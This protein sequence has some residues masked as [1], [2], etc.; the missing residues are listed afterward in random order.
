[1]AEAVA[2]SLVGKVVDSLFTKVKK[3]IGYMW[4]SKDN[5]EKL[6]S[7]VEKL[8]IMK[9]RV[10]D[11]IK[12]ALDDGDGLL[13]GVEKWVNEALAHISTT[14]EFL[15]EE[16]DA[17]KTCF[18]LRMCVNLKTL[19]HYGKEATNKVLSLEQHQKD[20]AAY[21]GDVSIPTPS[22]GILELLPRE[23]T[24]DLDTHKVVLEK[25]VE[26][27]EDESTQITGIWGMGGVGKTT[28][29]T[30]VAARV[31]HLFA[32]VIF[33]TVSRPVDVEKIKKDVEIAAKRITK[34]EKVLIILDDMWTELKL[35]D[36]G[37]PCGDGYPSC[38]ILLTSR[39]KSVC[40]AMNARTPIYVQS[41]PM[42]EAWVLFKRVVGERVETD[43][44]LK[45]VARKV[46]DGC[47]GLPLI[48]QVVG[49]ALKDKDDF[50]EWEKALDIIAKDETSDTG[51]ALR[52]EFARLKLSY[53]YLESEQVKS[54][55]ILCSMFP[56]DFQIPLERL[57]YYGVGL[58]V[59]KNLESL[60]VARNKVQGAVKIL[61]SSCL[62]LDGSNESFTKMHDVVREVALLI[63]SKD[64]NNVLVEAGKYLTKWEP[65][66]GSLESYTG[67]S[68]MNNRICKL[69]AGYELNIPL[70]RIFLIQENYRLSK[71]SDEFTQAMKEVEVIDFEYNNIG[72]LPKSLNQLTRLCMLNLGG[73]RSLRNVSIL[74]ELKQLEILI[75]S[76]TGITEIPQEIGKL[77]K[78]RLFH[79]ARCRG[80]SHIAPG[81]LSNLR[82]LE[83]LS[84]GYYPVE[85]G[86]YNSLV[87]IGELSKLTFLELSVQHIC[88][89][90]KG[91]YLK[92]LER[93]SIQI[94]PSEVD[95]CYD[96]S[97]CNR[98][99]ILS[100]SYIDIS[101]LMHV[102]KLIEVCDGIYLVSVKNLDNIMP[103]MYC[104]DFGLKTIK[105][106]SC[107]NL[108]CLV[109]SRVLDEMQTFHPFETREGVK[110]NIRFLSEVN[111]LWL[112]NL[113]G[114]KVIWNC[115][116]HY[117]SLNN[118]VTCM[119]NYCP[120]L[121]K[122]FTVTIAQG[123]VNLEKLQIWGC[124]SLKEVISDGD[125]ETSTGELD[126][127]VPAKNIVFPRL[128]EI[129]LHNMLKL[130][131]F[132]PGNT[133]I[134]YPSLV[135]VWITECDEMRK[136]SYGTND[137]PNLQFVRFH[138]V[139][140]K[141]STIDETFGKYIKLKYGSLIKHD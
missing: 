64:D 85:E 125:Q 24:D 124:K 132:Y 116:D 84:I 77:V 133:T 106:L 114:L 60:E 100:T 46:V 90:P 14:E 136:W 33:V 88:L 63:A 86:K 111:E 26:S 134:K 11:K 54:I 30:E 34:G 89:F 73:N 119:I 43:V 17:K 71:I 78:L 103:M 10:E 107:D 36:V 40:L 52:V 75:L 7:E 12:Q 98:T 67:I 1:M 51:R 140:M 104:E 96:I 39:E 50:K 57:A 25:I 31:K 108:L 101:H 93:F 123:L 42:Q 13:A 97:A 55:F 48:L 21:E 38:K 18:N 74:G 129:Q 6:R 137:T 37:I 72:S 120:K 45:Q 70:L 118:L 69:P 115:P 87:E 65:R 122:L 59:F 139:I 94:A 135:E 80:L 81:V 23:N 27:V 91:D 29:A 62:L 102:R 9:K 92:R 66:I 109:D 22:P 58:Q 3:E 95:G 131:S 49:K 112:R 138:T 19:H 117:I 20:G 110:G 82:W 126:M 41:L 8:K 56:E 47:G 130:T 113:R 5:V 127:V 128:A 15:Q 141:G 61:K 16:A 76:K 4:S 2:S 83:E 68:L 32:L 28:L 35:H 105:L 99:L 53:D 44:K 79:A 121:E